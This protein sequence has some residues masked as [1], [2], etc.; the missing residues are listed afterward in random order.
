MTYPA[1]MD[2]LT[3]RIMRIIGLALIGTLLVTACTLAFGQDNTVD[4]ELTFGEILASETDSIMIGCT[5][6]FGATASEYTCAETGSPIDLA[7]L[8]TEAALASFSDVESVSPWSRFDSGGIGRTYSVNN[9][10]GTAR[11]YVVAILLD[12]DDR[13]NTFIVI[14]YLGH[15]AR[16]GDRL[17]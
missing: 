7:K 8:R 10:D 15:Y 4:W 1:A 11:G 12:H 16:N 13:Y 14:D 17:D 2:N 3:R 5:D 6:I 9:D